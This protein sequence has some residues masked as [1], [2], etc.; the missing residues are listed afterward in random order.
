[1]LRRACVILVAH[2]LADAALV[3]AWCWAMRLI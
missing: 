2:L 3:A 1:M